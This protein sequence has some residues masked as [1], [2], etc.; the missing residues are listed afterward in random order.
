MHHK[1][2]KLFRNEE[3]L[4]LCPSRVAFFAQK[5]SFHGWFAPYFFLDIFWPSLIMGIPTPSN[6]SHIQVVFRPQMRPHDHCKKTYLRDNVTKFV[7]PLFFSLCQLI[8]APDLHAKAITNMA[9]ISRFSQA[10]LRGVKDT[11]K[12]HM[13]IYIIEIET[14]FENTKAFW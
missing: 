9:S 12:V 10:W 5:I 11:A 8:W 1:Y 4:Q 2:F 13:Q 6:A 14:I 3:S 7:Y